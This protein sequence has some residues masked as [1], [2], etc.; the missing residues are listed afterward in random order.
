MSEHNNREDK[1]EEFFQKKAGEY[2][3]SFR[4]EDWLKLE[5]KLD[6]RDA[7]IVYR[8]KVRWI[9]A[10]ALLIVS[11]LGYF[12]F[13]NYNRLNQL[14]QQLSDDSVNEFQQESSEEI[15]RNN[16]NQLASVDE[17]NGEFTAERKSDGAD[18]GR[19]S[20]FLLTDPG[21]A[22]AGL[23]DDVDQESSESGA[24]NAEQLTK[25]EIQA[26]QVVPGLSDY[27]RQKIYFVERAMEPTHT[28]IT[29]ASHT[30]TPSA[31][32][33]GMDY[34]NE[35]LASSRLSLGLATSPDFSTAG[36]ISNFYDPGYK[37][38]FTVE[39][40]LGSNFSFSTGIV[41]SM[42][43]YTARGGDYNPS[44]YWKDGIRPDEIIGECFLI[45]IPV[46]LK[47]NFLSFSRSRLFATAGFSS[48]IM[49]NED[50]NFK[51]SRDDSGL[52]QNW[53]GKTGTRHWLS[54]ASFSIG[55]EM[56][57]HQNWSIRAE[58]FVKIPINEV[59]WGNVNLYSM[60]SFISIQ[61]RL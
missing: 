46:T 20:L 44:F 21:L 15:L 26:T 35:R 53:S 12:T 51:Y 40:N 57:L 24:L 10:A 32:I 49:L 14:S 31:D 45:D 29:S 3:I 38:G 56:D 1:F 37:I 34:E 30:P 22:V 4:E 28:K 33:A 16:E 19:V 39:Y 48:Y 11:L 42:V 7:E 6:L 60:G 61:Y 25:R 47:Y 27:K 13:D 2:D 55:Y 23:D 58:P 5:K 36:S 50:Y 59:G 52:I 18:S 17:E 54:N 43:R 9:A 41:Q 8:R